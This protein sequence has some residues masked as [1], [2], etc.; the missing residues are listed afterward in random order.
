MFSLERIW[1]LIVTISL[2]LFTKFRSYIYPNSISATMPSAGLSNAF[3]ATYDPQSACPLFTQIPP[4]IRN[5][6]FKLALT[7]Y[8]D[9][10]H[11]YEPSAA[12]C[13]PEYCFRQRID[14]DLLRTCR[15][16][17]LEAHLLPVAINEHVFWCYRGPPGRRFA[18]D[19][20]G[21]FEM[22]KSRQRNAVDCVHF[23]TQQFWLEGQ[24][25]D[26]C[27]SPLMCPR[28][29]KI[30]LRH[31]DWWLNEYGA[32]LGIDPR[33]A[34]RV[35]WNEMGREP[36]ADEV[37]L[38]FGYQ[39]RHLRGLRELEMEFE[40]TASKSDELKAIVQRALA[41]KFELCDGSFLSTEGTSVSKSWWRRGEPWRQLSYLN[42]DWH[43]GVGQSSSPSGATKGARPAE[44]TDGANIAQNGPQTTEP[45]AS[46][47]GPIMMDPDWRSVSP[48]VLYFVFNVTWRARPPAPEQAPATLGHG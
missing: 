24:F 14:T 27:R 8:D 9:T 12:Y 31:T 22:M 25:R 37:Q 30:T 21:Y 42:D 2:S 16:V 48:D 23:F 39:F 35:P 29:I 47:T 40:T 10:H 36:R 34:N 43:S 17:Y 28:K 33:L 5:S 26:A 6:I 41:W 18:A 46:P 1:D 38:G 15:R 13:R 45:A 11:P 7:E 32:K 44:A 3:A 20:H 4:E 19:P